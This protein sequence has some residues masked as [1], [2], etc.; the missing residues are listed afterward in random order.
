MPWHG[1]AHDEFGKRENGVADGEY[2][3]KIG[4][5]L[6]FCELVMAGQPLRGAVEVLWTWIG[7]PSVDVRTKDL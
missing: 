3:G 6:V 5:D 1:C 4:E 7:Q 2:S